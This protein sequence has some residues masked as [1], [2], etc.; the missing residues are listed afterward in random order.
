MSLF[1]NGSF[2]AAVERQTLEGPNPI[3]LGGQRRDRRVLLRCCAL[4]WWER[5][6]TQLVV[7]AG[8]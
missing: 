4:R 8:E 2:L 1:P 6:G 7:A 3:A 5:T